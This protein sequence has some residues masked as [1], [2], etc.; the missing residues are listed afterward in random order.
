MAQ[1]GEEN[2][3]KGKVELYQTNKACEAIE[4]ELHWKSNHYIQEC[5]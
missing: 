1:E 4:D 3:K 2:S 5:Q